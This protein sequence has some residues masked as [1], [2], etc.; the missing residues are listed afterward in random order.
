MLSKLATDGAVDDWCR[1][2][3]EACQRAVMSKR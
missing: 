1:S 3:H 2:A